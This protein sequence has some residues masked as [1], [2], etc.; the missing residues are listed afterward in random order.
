MLLAAGQES[1]NLPFK[2]RQTNTCAPNENSKEVYETQTYC[3]Q[4]SSD[5]SK[6]EPNDA[7]RK[8]TQK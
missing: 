8:R 6:E 1:N 3:W 4:N 7:L 5:S 2:S